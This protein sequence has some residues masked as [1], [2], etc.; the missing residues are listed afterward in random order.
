MKNFGA[1]G[2]LMF[3]EGASKEKNNQIRAEC[4]MGLG[5]IG[6]QT[7]RSLL[8]AL[9]DDT[10]LVKD[11]ASKAILKNM[12]LSD[13][14]DQFEENSHQKQTICCTIKELLQSN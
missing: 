2:E 3:I 14:R 13:I 7:F 8:L 4:A 1:H 5:T 12:A 6:P 9:R 11:A 10:Q